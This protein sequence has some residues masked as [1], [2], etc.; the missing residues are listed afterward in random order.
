MPIHLTEENLILTKSI[1]IEDPRIDENLTLIHLSQDIQ[2]TKVSAV[3]LGDE[4]PGL[5]VSLVNGVDRSDL[6][7]V[8]Q[9]MTVTSSTIAQIFDNIDF[10]ANAGS[11][12]GLITTEFPASTGNITQLHLTISYLNKLD[13]I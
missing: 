1:T 6:D 2:I 4:T 3:I 13:I 7:T 12:I 9:D 11:F 5:N 8:I 10:D